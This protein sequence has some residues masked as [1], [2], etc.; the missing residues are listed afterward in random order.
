MNQRI[1]VLQEL[2]EQ[3]ERAVEDHP[4]ASKNKSRF[5]PSPQAPRL[6]LRALAVAV[7]VLLAVVLVTVSL[8][9]GG[10]QPLRGDQATRSASGSHHRE[11]LGGPVPTSG[12]ATEK[13]GAGAS[14][15]CV[16]S[17]TG[18]R[19][20][21]SPATTLAP[22]RL[23][24]RSKPAPSVGHGFLSPF[25]SQPGGPIKLAAQLYLP[26]RSGAKLPTGV[27]LVLKQRDIFGI[28]IVG[29]GLPANTKHDVYAIWLSNGR[30]ESKLVGFVSDP[31][32]HGRLQVAGPLPKHAF[33]YHRLLLTLEIRAE[34]KTPG[35]VV[36]EG[37]LH[38]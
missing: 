13:V 11:T 35:R 24:A 3:F 22:A 9:P 17:S 31:V 5:W 20:P 8:S 33:L 34:P 10:G 29:K 4:T 21:C 15:Y 38:R 25:S 27:G 12:D 2:G 37:S 18:K 16:N 30:R 26:A 19:T 36:L 28:S 32:K 23:P 1:R 14:P 7:V 6:G